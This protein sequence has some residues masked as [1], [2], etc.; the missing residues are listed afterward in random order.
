MVARRMDTMDQYSRAPCRRRLLSRRGSL[1]HTRRCVWRIIFYGAHTSLERDTVRDR[2]VNLMIKKGFFIW[3]NLSNTDS[4]W[5]R[6]THTITLGTIVSSSHLTPIKNWSKVR[7]KRAPP[8]GVFDPTP[9][10]KTRDLNLR[11]LKINFIVSKLGAVVP[12]KASRGSGGAPPQPPEAG[13]L[14]RFRWNRERSISINFP[15][16][17]LKRRL[18]QLPQ[19]S[20]PTTL[21][22]PCLI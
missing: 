12:K 11:H 17:A 16:R 21:T 3:K 10:H 4:K 1:I 19:L 2:S 14:G 20:Y 8:L 13:F 6:I 18:P 9:T 15:K 7:E 5:W 22:S